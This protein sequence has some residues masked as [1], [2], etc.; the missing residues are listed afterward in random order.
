MASLQAH[1]RLQFHRPFSS[2]P[3]RLYYLRNRNLSQRC[4][5]SVFGKARVFTCGESF[6]SSRG[7]CSNS[8]CCPC[9]AGT[10]IGN[11]SVEEDSERPPFDINL[12]VILAGFAFEA[13]TSPPVIISSSFVYTLMLI[14]GCLDSK[15]IGFKLI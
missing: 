11:A 9:K 10:E 6:K 3:H 2:L 7:A 4:S 15:R 8:I 13:Y 12:A 1:Y 14:G 5:A